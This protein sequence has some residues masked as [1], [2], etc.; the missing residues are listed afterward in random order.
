MLKLFVVKW[1]HE[2]VGRLSI[3]VDCLRK[4]KLHLARRKAF[5]AATFFNGCGELG[6]SHHD[7]TTDDTIWVNTG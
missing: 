2:S 7:C 6:H 4:S 5:V 1:Q 3:V